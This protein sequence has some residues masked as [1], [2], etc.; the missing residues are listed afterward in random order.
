MNILETS[1][2]ITRWICS[3]VRARGITRCLV[4][5]SG[6][7]R[8]SPVDVKTGCAVLSVFGLG[9]VRHRQRVREQ[10]KGQTSGNTSLGFAE[11]NTVI[12]TRKVTGTQLHRR[13]FGKS[14][15]C[16]D[17]CQIRSR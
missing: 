11:L 9:T 10:R 1:Q 4:Q 5:R 8:V 15:R 14:G 13:S 2:S 17:I 16:K 12:V 6:T 7:A 3:W